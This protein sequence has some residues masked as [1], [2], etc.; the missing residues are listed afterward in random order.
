MIYNMF[1]LL[2]MTTQVSQSLK[3]TVNFPVSVL[4]KLGKKRKDVLETSILV[5]Q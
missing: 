3:E 5:H 4:I 2:K 1:L